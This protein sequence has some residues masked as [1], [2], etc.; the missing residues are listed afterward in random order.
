MLERERT[1]D[2]AA[3]QDIEGAMGR[4]V[5][6]V[7]IA[8]GLWLGVP[9][10]AEPVAGDEAQAPGPTV[11]VQAVSVPSIG[12]RD[13]AAMVLLGSALIGLAAAVRRAS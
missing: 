7:M 9:A 4:F 6:G 10:P 8:G 1:A 2:A 12:I 13:E 11:A 3:L 5:V